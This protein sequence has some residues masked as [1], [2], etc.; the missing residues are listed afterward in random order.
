MRDGV[1]EEAEGPA[2]FDDVVDGQQQRVLVCAQHGAELK[3]A[4]AKQRSALEIGQRRALRGHHLLHEPLARARARAIGVHADEKGQLGSRLDDLMRGTISSHQ[5]QSRAISGNQ[6]AINSAVGST[7]C[8]GC[9]SAWRSK[10]VRNIG[11]L[12]TS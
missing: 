8:R 2:I 10:R 11:V 4:D 3:H 5:R 1:Q 7:T 6:E 9:G 12:A